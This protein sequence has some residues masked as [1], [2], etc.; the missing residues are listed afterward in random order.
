MVAKQLD[1]NLMASDNSWVVIGK[2]LGLK[3]LMC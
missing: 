1:D 2:E 3:Y